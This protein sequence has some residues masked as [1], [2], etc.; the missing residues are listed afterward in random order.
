MKRTAVLVLSLCC[1]A[2]CGDEKSVDDV[3]DAR[4]SLVAFA[5]AMDAGDWKTAQGYIDQTSAN[6]R[7]YASLLQQVAGM[8]AMRQAV[9]GEVERKFGRS[10]RDA[11]ARTFLLPRVGGVE[12]PY[13]QIVPPDGV[14]VDEET[15]VPVPGFTGFAQLVQRGDRYVLDVNE[16]LRDAA[17]HDARIKMPDYVQSAALFEYR[18]ERAETA[19]AFIESLGGDAHEEPK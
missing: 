6:G 1:F 14:T 12:G 16:A 4:A 19:E 2:G 15:A 5:Q 13:A 3:P 17:V 8:L 9:L 11:A 18:L 7:E 10:A